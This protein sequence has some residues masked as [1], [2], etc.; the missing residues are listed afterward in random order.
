MKRCGAKVKSG[1]RC[2]NKALDSSE[3]CRTHQNH[4]SQDSLIATT[5]GMLIGNVVMPGIGGALLGSIAANV[6]RSLFRET[7]KQKS[8]IFVSFDFEHDRVLKDFILGQAKLK[9]SPFEVIDHSLKE[10]AP[11]PEWE[12]RARAAICRADIVLVMVGPYTYKAH[13]VLKEVAM[14]R[15]AGI[16]IVQVIGYK[17]SNYTSIPNA[18]RLYSWSWENLKMLLTQ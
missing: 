15:Q 11:E 10:A 13:G 5:A 6:A 8:R 3:F 14:A 9:D 12:S 4:L 18:G 16:K 1:R 2:L 7:E 17:N